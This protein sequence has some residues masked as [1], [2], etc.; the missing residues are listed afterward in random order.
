[1]RGRGAP[2]GGY[3]GGRQTGV[4]MLRNTILSKEQ[5]NSTRRLQKDY[6][7]LKNAMVP[8]VG[9]SAAPTDDD[10]F[11]WHANIRGPE[12]TA[13]YGGVFH[14]EIKFPKDYPM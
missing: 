14:L 5:T 4:A 3:R 2:R 10:F 13:F 9:V 11:T 1:M 8:L 12:T 7:E 6:Q